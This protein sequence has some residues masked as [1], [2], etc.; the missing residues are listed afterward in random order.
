M[1]ARRLPAPLRGQHAVELPVGADG[2]QDDVDG[3]GKQAPEQILV[4]H[5]AQQ[6]T[7]RL[8]DAPRVL[9]QR[10]VA[11]PREGAAVVIV[12]TVAARLGGCADP[13]AVAAHHD[14]GTPEPESIA[15]V[16]GERLQQLRH[17]PLTFDRGVQL[18]ERRELAPCLS[19]EAVAHGRAARDD[20][21]APDERNRRDGELPVGCARAAREEAG[22]VRGTRDADEHRAPDAELGARS[23]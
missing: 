22:L 16:R 2:H 12:G 14:R 15:D 19:E 20:E 7:A 13:A 10:L 8:E 17:A 6:R 11:E 4:E 3:P 18:D 1:R 9:T 5:A 21:T 23:S